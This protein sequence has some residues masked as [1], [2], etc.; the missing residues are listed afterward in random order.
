M[1][2][3]FR[4]LRILYNLGPP[5]AL[6]T[7]DYY[8]SL[9]V[10][11]TFDWEAPKR[12][13]RATDLAKR[14]TRLGPTFIK[15]AQIL[16]A[17]AD[18][19]P[20]TYLDE[21]KKLHDRVPPTPRRK[22][23]R[24]FRKYAGTS[25]DEIFDSFETTPIA[26]ASLGQ[27]HKAAYKGRPVAVKIL[28]PEIR[29]VVD[30]DLR[31]MALLLSMASLFY[32]NTQLDSLIAIF[33]EFNR[34]IF[35]EMD[36]RREA[37]NIAR[38]R[39]RYRD[40]PDVTVPE[41]INEISNRDILVMEY[42]EG[43]KI[44]DVDKL[45]AAGHDTDVLIQRLLLLFGNQILKDGCFHADPHPGNIF[46]GKNGDIQL[47]DFGLVL[48]VSETQR[49]RYIEAILAVVRG[50]YD[51]LISVGFELNMIGADVNQVVLR[52]AA[53]RLMAIRFRDDLGP[54][55]MQRIIMQIMKV[56]YEFPIRMPSELVYVF[57]T[58]TLIEGIGAIYRPGYS[59]PRDS[60]DVLK[61]ILAEELA[62]INIEDEI[63]RR[64]I[65]EGKDLW[66]MYNNLKQVLDLTAREELAI[67]VHRSDML[68]FYAIVGYTVRRMIALMS[69]LGTG[70]LSAMVFLNTGN[71]WVLA[72]GG[73]LTGIG[74]LGLFL[75]PTIPKIPRIVAPYRSKEE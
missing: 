61:D 42:L 57:K 59:V 70:F 30:K 66:A 21:L 43:I 29:S 41:V 15:L 50:D 39:E 9:L 64:V 45:R 74:M 58:G 27:V 67:R 22:I 49:K 35:Q 20:G 17:R 13:K 3:I 73:L 54:L 33:E 56:F 7:R 34:T 12:R 62:E 75:L 69:V 18:L 65:R 10:G 72:A 28:K 23:L 51:K 14:L 63:A 38:F 53:Q 5:L 44:T 25:P 55:E 52:Q 1:S 60:L 46:V 68:D 71:W 31:V 32:Q 2:L 26:S 8:R 37:Q 47:V 24:Y 36:F 40:D 6:M 16:A 19:F 48:D 11:E 4:F